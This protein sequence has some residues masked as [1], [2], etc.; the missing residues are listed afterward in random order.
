MPVRCGRCGRSFTTRADPAAVTRVDT[1]VHLDIGAATSHGLANAEPAPGFLVQHVV[2]SHRDKRQEGAILIAAEDAELRTLGVALLPLLD[3]WR[4]GANKESINLEQAIAG[5]SATVI[6]IDEGEVSFGRLG[7]ARCYLYR[8]GQL[9]QL[10]LQP[11]PGRMRLASGDWLLLTQG[12]IPLA[13]LKQAIPSA[14]S[15]D[16][17]TQQIL[18]R[19]REQPDGEA[20]TVLAVRCY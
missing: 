18:E 10:A 20:G 17:L 14:A 2:G 1:M 19:C 7:A 16:Q 15:A 13:A 8:G 3:R 9:L 6:V 11:N 4:G 5:A 12:A